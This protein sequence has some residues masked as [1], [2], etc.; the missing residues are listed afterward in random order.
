MRVDVVVVGAGLAGLTAASDLRAAGASAVVLEAGSRPGG[1]ARTIQLE[2]GQWAESGGEWIDTAHVHVLELLQ[3]YGL[4]TVGDGAPW[5][6]REEGWI[7]DASGLRPP[8]DA[9]LRD[10]EIHADFARFDHL[11]TVLA[12]GIADP[13]DPVAHPDAAMIDARS[14]ADLFDELDLGEF[15]R[16]MLTRAIE[17]EYTC[18]PVEISALFLAQQRAVEL[19]E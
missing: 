11:V 16:F 10:A 6:E 4:R 2:G 12:G 14:G 5:W 3:R 15:A 17:F 13:A 1:R 8:A 18:E 19:S 7:D 9:W